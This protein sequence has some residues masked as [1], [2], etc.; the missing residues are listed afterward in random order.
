MTR[1][2]VKSHV[3]LAGSLGD[4][5]ASSIKG[6][7]CDDGSFWRRRPLEFRYNLRG[8][9]VSRWSRTCGKASVAATRIVSFHDDA[10]VTMMRERERVCDESHRQRA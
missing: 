10:R 1:R 3:A 4:S 7:F 9:L 2:G 5:V 8:R 6:E